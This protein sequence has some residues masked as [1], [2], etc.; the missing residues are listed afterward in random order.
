MRFDSVSRWRVFLEA[1]DTLRQVLAQPIPLSQLIRHGRQ[2]A[3]A[4]RVKRRNRPM[5]LTQLRRI[6]ARY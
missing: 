1:R 6:F 2:I 3:L 4:L 5:Q